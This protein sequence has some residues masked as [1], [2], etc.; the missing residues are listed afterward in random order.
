MPSFL[1]TILARKRE[2]V[3][4]L[5]RDRGATVAVQQVPPHRS[6]AKSLESA[7]HL[8][9]I[10]EVKKA[11]PSKGVIRADFEPVAIARSYERAV[12]N[13]ISV[14]TD[15]RFFGGGPSYVPAVRAAVALP[16]LRKDF[17]IDIVQVE[18]T[19]ALGAD[20]L[21]LIA[22][23]LDNER[24]RD[25]YEASCGLGIE[26]LVELHHLRE[27]DRVMKLEPRLVGINNRDLS[28]FVVDINVTLDL[29]RHIPKEAT[30]ISE[31]GI[32]C[33]KEARKLQGAGVKALLV[34][35]ALMRLEDPSALVRELR[36][37]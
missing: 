33:G 31:S 8:G 11:S 4:L 37:E 1:D 18:Q 3:A 20:A 28:T 30:V 34:G 32:F 25:L 14:L 19:A 35:E 22:A 24:L 15:E 26:S 17:I 27:L 10:A 36:G 9:I 16:V 12:V 29:M 21:L 2:E 6:F 5:K 13:A 7:A 23:V